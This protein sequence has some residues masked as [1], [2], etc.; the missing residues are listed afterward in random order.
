MDKGAD[1][2]LCLVCELLGSASHTAV[3]N[4]YNQGEHFPIGECHQGM[5]M[6]LAEVF[7]DVPFLVI[8]KAIAA[9]AAAWDVGAERPS[10]AALESEVARQLDR[11]GGWQS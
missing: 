6:R 10:E 5:A 4:V 9:S 8:V 3:R 1:S 11:R 7:S 2:G